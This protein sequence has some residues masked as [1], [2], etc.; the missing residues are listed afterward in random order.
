MKDP[1]EKGE[2]HCP[3]K[4]ETAQELGDELTLEKDT[5]RT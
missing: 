1:D 3:D 4:Y 5:H 2:G